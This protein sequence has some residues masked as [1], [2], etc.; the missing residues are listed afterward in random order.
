MV[1]ILS[2][3]GLPLWKLK[4][5]PSLARVLRVT[6]SFDSSFLLE[7]GCHGHYNLLDVMIPL[8]CFH[9]CHAYS[10]GSPAINW[11]LCGSLPTKTYASILYRILHSQAFLAST[12]KCQEVWKCLLRT[13][14]ELWSLHSL[15]EITKQSPVSRLSLCYLLNDNLFSFAGSSWLLFSPGSL[16]ITQVHEHM[17][18]ERE[19]KMDK[20]T[21][22]PSAVKGAVQ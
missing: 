19:K 8:I 6:F 1:A 18:P 15:G 21:L 14:F 4:D 16:E 10:R 7:T 2:S 5:V 20:T 12:W 17:G 3:S 9:F 13:G 11:T 22:H